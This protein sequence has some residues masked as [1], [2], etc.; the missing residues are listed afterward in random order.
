MILSIQKTYCNIYKITYT[1]NLLI[2][3][4]YNIN[5][6]YI[7]MIQYKNENKGCFHTQKQNLSNIVASIKK[8]AL[9][10]IFFNW[11]WKYLWR[12]YA[13]VATNIKSVK[14]IFKMN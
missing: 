13:F 4:G 3:N 2:C 12:K 9:T 14:I 5:T 7:F 11:F 6:F 10:N 1:F 8:S